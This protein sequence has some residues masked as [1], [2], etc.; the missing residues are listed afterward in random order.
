V[1]KQEDY[2]LLNTADILPAQ[3][4]DTKQQHMLQIQVTH[5]YKWE[6]YTKIIS[7]EMQPVTYTT[8]TSMSSISSSPPDHAPHSHG[9]Q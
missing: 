6:G 1:Y 5:G 3:Y 7:M 8:R 4:S 9:L 2:F